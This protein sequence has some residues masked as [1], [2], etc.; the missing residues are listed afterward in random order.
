MTT[1][2]VRRPRRSDVRADILAAAT[3]SF[4]TRGYRRT[5]VAELAAEAGYSKGAVYS[6]FGGKP[7]LFG[8]VMNARASEF[9][10]RALRQFDL[11]FSEHEPE[12]SEL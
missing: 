12:R 5:N 11:L 10:D 6:N 3:R 9:A 2:P 4:L 7:E 8:A 1:T